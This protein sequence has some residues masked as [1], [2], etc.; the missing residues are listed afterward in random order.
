MLQTKEDL[1]AFVA[2]GT[3]MFLLLGFF[4]INFLLVYQRR[5]LEYFKERERLKNKFHQEL[6]TAHLEIHEHTLKHIAQEIHDN[7][8]QVLSFIKLSLG[9]FNAL[10]RKEKADKIED[11]RELVTYVINELRDLSKSLSY[12]KIGEKG[13]T[14]TIRFETDRITKSAA[15]NI[16]LQIEGE[17]F[18]LGDQR[19]LVLYRI[20]QESIHNIISHSKA[21]NVKI[22]LQYSPEVFNL[23]LQDDGIGFCQ[24]DVE[25]SGGIGIK[26]MRNR[27]TLIGAKLSILTSL[28]EGCL[29]RVTLAPL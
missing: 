8:G 20:F 26:N 23:I 5:Q 18:P 21:Q 9:S 15:F 14:E 10:S 7:I 6:L 24:E 12:E 13:L 27:A 4:I 29:T 17:S 11:T 25:Q 19:E 2:T 22:I 1:I 16:V 3:I 28:D